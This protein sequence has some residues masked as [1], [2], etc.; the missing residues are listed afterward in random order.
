M[1]I[2]VFV[3]VFA[4]LVGSINAVTLPVI[5]KVNREIKSNPEN[6]FVELAT[7]DV[8]KYKEIRVV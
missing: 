7:V 3:L 1:K 2:L 4:C 8:S 6:E 5:F